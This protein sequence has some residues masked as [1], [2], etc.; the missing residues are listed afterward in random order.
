MSFKV[1]SWR[2]GIASALDSYC[3]RRGGIDLVKNVSLKWVIGAILVITAVAFIIG[4]VARRSGGSSDLDPEP[5][6][7]Q[8][9]TREPSDLDPEARTQQVIESEITRLG[10]SGVEITDVHCMKGTSTRYEC[11][12]TSR[13]NGVEHTT[14]GTLNCDGTDPG[15]YCVWRGELPGA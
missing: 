3:D 5:T 7:Q 14:D 12:V 6:T 15:D 10:V 1:P 11:H 4:A 8:I 13:Q 9:T 2:R